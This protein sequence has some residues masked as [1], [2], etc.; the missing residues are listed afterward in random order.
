[1]PGPFLES[2]V[3]DKKTND[4]DFLTAIASE[5]VQNIMMEEGSGGAFKEDRKRKIQ[6]VPSSEDDATAME[7]QPRPPKLFKPLIFAPKVILANA[8]NGHG[9]GGHGHGGHGHGPSEQH[10]CFG[11]GEL[12]EN[13][14]PDESVVDQEVRNALISQS[15][16]SL[17]LNERLKEL[18]MK[19]SVIAEE[20]SLNDNLYAGLLKTG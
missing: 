13:S 5:A 10:H 8:G 4:D 16:H 14:K 6:A 11:G 7:E 18:N 17:I 3:E 1:M 9:H 2:P 15:K 20:D 19:L 12:A